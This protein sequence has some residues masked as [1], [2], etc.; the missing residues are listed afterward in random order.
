MYI[1]GQTKEERRATIER[2]VANFFDEKG[3]LC[4][5]LFEPEVRSLALSLTTEKKEK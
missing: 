4:I 5:D 3:Q 1:D 2:S